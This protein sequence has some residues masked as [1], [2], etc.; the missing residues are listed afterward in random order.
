[1]R[2]ECEG[3]ILDWEGT[4]WPLMILWEPMHVAGKGKIK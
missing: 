2:R 1:M 4:P 3:G